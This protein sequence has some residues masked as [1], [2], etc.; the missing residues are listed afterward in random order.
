MN[1]IIQ[2]ETT[3]CAIASSAAIASVSYEEAKLVAN[4]LDIYA[5]DQELWSSISHIKK[6][7][8]KFG[9]STADKEQPFAGWRSLPNCALMSIKWHVVNGKPFWH[10]VVFVREG[11]NEYVLDSKKLLK[12]N[13]RTDFGRMKPKWFIEV[14]A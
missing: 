9:I 5:E 14:Y 4:S 13:K 8:K 2:Q 11:S 7:L 10:W 3:G 12:T 6:I 1:P